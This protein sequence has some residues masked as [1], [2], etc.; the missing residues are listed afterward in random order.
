MSDEQ[1]NIL[2]D[3]RDEQTLTREEFINY[4]NT[5][6]L[7]NLQEVAD[8]LLKYGETKRGWLGVRIQVVT[9]E[10]AEV[11]GMTEPKGALVASVSDNSPAYKAGIKPGDI[12]V[13]FD[14]QE[15][16]TMRTLPKIVAKAEVGK[17]V[18]VK[19]WR[20]KKLISK[21]VL[22]GRLETSKEFAEKNKKK[23]TPSEI[24]SLKIHVRLLNEKDISER[25]LPK[26]TT[27]LVITKI[28]SDSPINNYLEVNNIIIEVQKT[29]IRN[30]KQLND[31]VEKNINGGE[32]TLLIVIY[33]NNNERRYLGIRFN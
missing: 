5:Q 33:D 22:L 28:A 10:I 3:S 12:I 8:Q 2:F 13:E 30:I 7:T 9:K 17:R 21:K 14:G 32:T 31:I 29:K 26:N 16:D 24:N 18:I 20:D 25:N 15:V 27:G 11:E 6:E 19:I 1:F 23:E 4:I